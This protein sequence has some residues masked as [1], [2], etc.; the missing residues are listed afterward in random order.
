[1]I[2][3]DVKAMADFVTGLGIGEVY[4][5][6]DPVGLAKAAMQVLSDPERYAKAQ[7]ADPELLRTYSWERQEERLREVYARLLGC[8]PTDFRRPSAAPGQ[9]I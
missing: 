6:D 1:M 3:S 7:A 5:A 4:V 9:E 8:S 2:V